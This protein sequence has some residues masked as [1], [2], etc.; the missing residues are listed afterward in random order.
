LVF[1][2]LN[3]GAY[4]IPISGEY[5]FYDSDSAEEAGLTFSDCTESEDCLKLFTFGSKVDEIIVGFNIKS[6]CAT[7]VSTDKNAMSNDV[8]V[9][10]RS[11]DKNQNN[12]Y[13]ET[14]TTDTNYEFNEAV[15]SEINGLV[16]SDDLN[17]EIDKLVSEEGDASDG[18]VEVSIVDDVHYE[19]MPGILIIYIL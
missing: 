9:L 18:H 1:L 14:S 5:S 15:E 17:N 13:N 4:N 16:S 8:P 2:T 10:T 11:T 3:N 19:D 12:T 6:N 7:G